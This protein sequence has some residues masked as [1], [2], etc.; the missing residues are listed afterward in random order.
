V[1]WY[2]VVNWLARA[3]PGNAAASNAAAIAQD[4][5]FMGSLL[6]QNNT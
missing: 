4:N 6:S 5:C 2:S 1:N 3:A